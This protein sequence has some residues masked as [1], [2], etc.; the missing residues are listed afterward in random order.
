MDKNPIPDQFTVTIT[1]EDRQKAEGFCSNFSCL[2]A[3]ALKRTFPEAAISEGWNHSH[4]NKVQYNHQNAGPEELCC[5]IK[6]EQKPFYG[7]EVVGK[8]FTFTRE[9]E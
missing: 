6:V 5:E 8:T 4:I 3:T 2:M 7:P 9:K 1:E